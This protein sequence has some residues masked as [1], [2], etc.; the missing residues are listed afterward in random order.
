VSTAPALTIGAVAEN[1]YAIALAGRIPVKITNENGEVHAGDMLTSAS[2]PG[3]AMKATTSGSV[4]GRVINEPDAMNS[5]DVALPA[6]EESV[7]DGPGVDALNTVTPQ[8]STSTQQDSSQD[9]SGDEELCG[10]AMLF[11]GLSDFLGANIDALSQEYALE[12]PETIEVEGLEVPLEGEDENILQ[13]KIMAFLDFTQTKRK[14]DAELQS[15]FTDKLAAAFEIIS[16]A[17]YTKGLRVNSIDVFDEELVSMM[18]DVEFFGTPYLNK[19]TGGFAVVRSGARS[20]DVVFEK[21]YLEQPIVNVT[22]TLED[23]EDAEA[24]FRDDIRYVVTKKTT[25]GFR[26]LINK[27][28]PSDTKFSWTAFAVKSPNVFFSL[29]SEEAVDEGEVYEET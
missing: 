28:A 1:S 3:Y 20:V 11:V 25:H 9:I 15:V 16:P 6:I 14:E 18:S 24:I 29:L 26:I 22:I 12:N 2:R 23:A 8:T 5:C 27:D 7:G 21:D 13:K 10:Y 19:D 4:L 17:M